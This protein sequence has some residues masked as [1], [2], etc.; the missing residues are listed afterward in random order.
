M[1][2]LE[3]K[4][5]IYFVQTENVWNILNTWTKRIIQNRFERFYLIINNILFYV[6]INLEKN[7]KNMSF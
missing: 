1:L 2:E 5:Y 7:L 6:N 3:I 4:N